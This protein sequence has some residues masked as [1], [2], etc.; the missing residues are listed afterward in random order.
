MTN[1]YSQFGRFKEQMK[2]NSKDKILLDQFEQK[3]ILF[4]GFGGRNKTVSRWLANFQ[5]VGLIKIEKDS[6]DVWF[7]TIV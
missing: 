3:M 5:N 1:Y 2:L 7:V 4:F 6:D